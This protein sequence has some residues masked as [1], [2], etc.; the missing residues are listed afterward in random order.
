MFLRAFNS[1]LAGYV[2]GIVKRKSRTKNGDYQR[3]SQQTQNVKLCGPLCPCP[4]SLSLTSSALSII[5]TSVMLGVCCQ[6]CLPSRPAEQAC[7]P[8]PCLVASMECLGRRAALFGC[9]RKDG[10]WA[11]IGC[12]E[13]GW[14][15]VLI[16]SLFARANYNFSDLFLKSD[17]CREQL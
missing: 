3:V 16:E 15:L 10:R 5:L 12:F 2:G 14:N 9:F 1:A 13:G 17:I 4:L 6:A 11:A 8:P 7:R